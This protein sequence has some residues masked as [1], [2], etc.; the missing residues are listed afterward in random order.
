MTIEA[1]KTVE[2]FY[3]VTTYKDM[4]FADDV[5]TC[6]SFDSYEKA[7]E[8]YNNTINKVGHTQFV[9][10]ELEVELDGDFPI[11]NIR[12]ADNYK[13][14]AGYSIIADFGDRIGT[15]TF[16]ETESI[17]ELVNEF[18]TITGCGDKLYE[19]AYNSIPLIKAEKVS[20]CVVF[21]DNVEEVLMSFNIPKEN[22][23]QNNFHVL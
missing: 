9:T 22:S 8:E 18:N 19:K 6:D 13:E 5:E 11:D 4:E 15:A 20:A 21:K 2:V 16:S 7:L 14:V 1:P 23:W 17:E 3:V 10:L 12:L